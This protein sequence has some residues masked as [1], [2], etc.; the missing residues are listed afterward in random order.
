M[1]EN[2]TGDQIE[3]KDIIF[4]LFDTGEIIADELPSADELCDEKL[5]P[6]YLKIQAV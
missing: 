3:V 5:W 2:K 6:D 4:N 1:N